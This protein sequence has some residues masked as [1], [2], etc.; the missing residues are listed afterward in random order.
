VVL[1]YLQP[2]PS[3]NGIRGLYW[4]FVSGMYQIVEIIQG[5][6]PKSAESNRGLCVGDLEG[7][8]TEQLKLRRRQYAEG[9]FLA[10]TRNYMFQ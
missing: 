8:F 9:Y 7:G 6:K 2:H 5:I 3:E 1:C 10:G 4:K